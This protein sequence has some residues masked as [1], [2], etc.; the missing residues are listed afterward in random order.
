MYL[1]RV[2]EVLQALNALHME[3]EVIYDG[4]GAQGVSKAWPEVPPSSDLFILRF[5]SIGSLEVSGA[6]CH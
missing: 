2:A 3:V 6:T 5:C 1:S 4:A